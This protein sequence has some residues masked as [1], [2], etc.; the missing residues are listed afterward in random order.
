MCIFENGLGVLWKVIDVQEYLFKTA[1]SLSYHLPCLL[2]L[3]KYVCVHVCAHAGMCIIYEK[4]LMGEKRNFPARVKQFILY[5]EI[6]C[7]HVNDFTIKKKKHGPI[8]V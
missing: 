4:V 2:S 7:D 5:G 3:T 8:P 1:K 6:L